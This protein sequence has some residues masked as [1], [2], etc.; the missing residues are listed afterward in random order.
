MSATKTHP[1]DGSGAAAVA[2]SSSLDAASVLSNHLS[3]RY[4]QFA[5]VLKQQTLPLAWL[6]LDAINENCRRISA[7]TSGKR[8]RIVTKSIRCPDALRYL[9]ESGYNFRGLMAYQAAEAVFLAKQ[10]FDDIL[11]AYPSCQQTVIDAV[12]E[13]LLKG[14][15]ITCMADSV[16]HLHLLNTAGK[17]LRISIPCCIDVDMSLSLP[18]LHFGVRR[19]PLNDSD[20][21]AE[22]LLAAQK[23]PFVNVVGYM[24]YEAQIAGVGDKVPGKHLQ[25]SVLPLLK[26]QA[27][28]AVRK[29][30]KS[31]NELFATMD[32]PLLIANGGGTGSMLFSSQD[33]AL[34]EVAVGSG[35]FAPR[36]FDFYHD[37]NLSPAAG[38]AMEVVRKPSSDYVTCA[39]GG[40][41]ASGSVGAEKLPQAW[42]PKGLH[43]DEQEGAGEVQTPLQ[44]N[45]E[46]LFPGAP[47]FFR[48]AKAGELCEHFNEL[49]VMA[50]GK[51]VDRWPTYRGLGQAFL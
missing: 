34:N 43:L 7:L 8:V 14:K 30:R 37:L 21:V 32:L 29:R 13:Q 27:M 49:V 4:R 36:L 16:E 17:S 24:G 9:F 6:D 31:I 11:I 42:L 38:F 15:S 35:F 12:A 28:R 47:V 23:F 41:I 18:G 45:T 33:T 5:S 50:S 39:G 51:V 20:K 22:I 10:G 46:G 44:G 2:A 1:T 48:H 25:N 19:S 40:F 26:K 3:Q